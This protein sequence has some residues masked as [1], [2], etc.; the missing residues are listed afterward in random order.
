MKSFNI[1]HDKAFLD[2]VIEEVNRAR[3][4]FPDSAATNAAL[5]EEVGELSKA[6]MYE[7][8]CNV[9][10]EAVQ[11]ACMALRIAVEGDSTM[12]E[13]RI[14]KVHGGNGSRYGGF[15]H[16]MPNSRLLRKRK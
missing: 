7:P 8:Y 6:L 15:E 14:K 9:Y 16:I 10:A 3:I 1:D 4:K 5:V 13:F 2:L 11:V 12:D